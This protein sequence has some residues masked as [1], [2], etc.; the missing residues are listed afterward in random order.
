MNPLCVMCTAQGRVTA[1]QV[2][3]HITPHKGNEE[4]FWDE[5]NWQ[6]LCATHH[7]SDKQLIENG[8]EA[9][10]TIGTDG[11]PT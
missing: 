4:L 10:K 2:V 3:D 8:K 7:S 1:A 9:R 5:S 11:W 6:S